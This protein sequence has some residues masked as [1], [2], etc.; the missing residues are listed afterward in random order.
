MDFSIA[1]T[2][3]A[4]DVRNFI[5]DFRTKYLPSNNDE[6]DADVVLPQPPFPPFYNGTYGE[7]LREAKQSLRFLVIYLHGDSHED[8]DEFCR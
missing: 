4:A 5:T 3:P 1:L 6:N 2:D 7:A 8:T